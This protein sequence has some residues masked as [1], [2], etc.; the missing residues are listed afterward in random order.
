MAIFHLS[1]KIISKSQGRSAIAASAYRS[2]QKLTD[3]DTGIISDYTKKNG[4]VHSEIMLCANAPEEFLDRETLWNSVQKIEKSKDAQLA[5]EFEISLPKEL[6]RDQ[7]LD[8]L[9]EYIFMNFT[10]KGMIADFAIHDKND[11]NP[12]AHVMCTTRPLKSDGSWGVKE[13][14]GFAVDENGAR[15]PIID[16]KTGVQKVD[17]NNRKQWKRE[18]IQVN[19]WNNRENCELWR[20]NWAKICNEF[21]VGANK[22][23]HRSFKRQGIT[24]RLPL[25]NETMADRQIEKKGGV[26]KRCEIN[27]K[28][29]NQNKD[30][31]NSNRCRRRLFSKRKI[32]KTQWG[33]LENA[34]AKAN[35][36]QQQIIEDFIDIYD[37]CGVTE[38]AVSKT[39]QLE[40]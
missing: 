21:L 29:R 16:K 6:D 10:S 11:G 25:V 36:A 39:A 34:L 40:R 22:I 18:T 4:V 26:S 15:I 3:D 5:R 31:S 28:I 12:H 37:F 2:G 8:L 17:K 38:E 33:Q 9:R 19:D 20:A 23:D 32:V 30:F 24:D 1:V 7:Q 35:S 14:K 27:R 13:R